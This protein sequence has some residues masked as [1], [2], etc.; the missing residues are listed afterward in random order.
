MNKAEYEAMMDQIRRPEMTPEEVAK[1][2]REGIFKPE[3]F[4]SELLRPPVQEQ[5]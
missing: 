1:T 2:I 4:P 5:E 3:D